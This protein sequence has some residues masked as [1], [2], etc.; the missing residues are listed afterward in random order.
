[1]L[2]AL[3]ADDSLAIGRFMFFSQTSHF[4][5]TIRGRLLLAF[6]ISCCFGL[7]GC[8]KLDEHDRK[9]K[10]LQAQVDSYDLKFKALEERS[11]GNWVLWLSQEWNDPSRP[12]WIWPKMISA[13]NTKA[14]CISS[15][16]QYSL[17]NGVAISADPHKFSDGQV[18]YTYTCLPPN[19]DLRPRVK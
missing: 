19:V 18:T 15:A 17:P 9:L 14:E 2:K 6:V 12:N 13:F 7:S 11:Q 3:E 10:E 1:M 8:S 5:N 16:S 4:A